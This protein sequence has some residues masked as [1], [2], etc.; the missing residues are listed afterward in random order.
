MGMNKATIDDMFGSN[1]DRLIRETFQY[2]IDNDFSN[3]LDKLEND[4]E[5]II[6][7]WKF[8]EIGLPQMKLIMNSS[9]DWESV[10]DLFCRYNHK[11]EYSIEEREDVGVNLLLNCF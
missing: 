8:P 7:R 9:P 10:K 2:Y 4:E 1:I 11:V 5:C 6:R 3:D